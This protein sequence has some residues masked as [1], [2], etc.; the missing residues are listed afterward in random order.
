MSMDST[1]R[2]SDRVSNYIK[3]RPTYP[4]AV[5]SDLTKAGILLP[6]SVVANIGS[7]TGLPAL[8]AEEGCFPKGTRSWR[9]LCELFHIDELGQMGDFIPSPS[10]PGTEAERGIAQVESE[11]WRPWPSCR[12]VRVPA[13]RCERVR[14]PRETA[15]GF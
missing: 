8:P 11:A 12:P 4:P 7:G 6:S 2:F 13:G 15:G 1:R 14:A 3:Y 5:T 10:P 9:N